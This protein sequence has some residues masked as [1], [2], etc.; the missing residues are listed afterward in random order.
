L[1]PPVCFADVES[2]FGSL[3]AHGHLMPLAF[4]REAIAG[5]S[6]DGFTLFGVHLIDC[7]LSRMTFSGADLRGF[8]LV[9]CRLVDCAFDGADLAGAYVHGCSIRRCSFDEVRLSGAEWS[10]NTLAECVPAWI[11]NLPDSYRNQVSGSGVQP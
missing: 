2:T 3:I 4:S 8:S 11:E 10:R 5:M 1:V 7:D 6:C 9:G